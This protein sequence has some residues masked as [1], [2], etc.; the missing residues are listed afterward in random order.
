[1]EQAIQRIINGIKAYKHEQTVLLRLIRKHGELTEHKF[2]EIF[3]HSGSLWNR[4][5]KSAIDGKIRPRMR[6]LSGRG[7]SGDS[8]LLGNLSADKDRDWWLDL[9]QHMQSLGLVL[10]RTDNDTI[11]YF[12]P[13]EQ[14]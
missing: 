2:D 7:I 4:S 9:L 13:K 6:K 3:F 12:L 11:I 14:P 1:M 5:Y 10:T 8:F